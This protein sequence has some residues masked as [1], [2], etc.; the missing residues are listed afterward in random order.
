MK[1]KTE[2]IFIFLND[3]IRGMY[4]YGVNLLVP[5]KRPGK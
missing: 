2:H 4:D 3:L 1:M 5:N